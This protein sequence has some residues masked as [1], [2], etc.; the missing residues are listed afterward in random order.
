MDFGSIARQK[1]RLVAKDFNQKEEIDYSQIF[2]LV[3]KSTIVH[4]IFALTTQLNGSLKQHY[5][6]NAFL[7]Y[8]L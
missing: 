5:V 3:V 6:K 1:V 4:L 7:Y 2:S 8:L